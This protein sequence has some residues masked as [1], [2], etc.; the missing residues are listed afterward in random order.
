MNKESSIWIFQSPKYWR[1]EDFS[2]SF[3]DLQNLEAKPFSSLAQTR[4]DKPLTAPLILRGSTLQAKHAKLEAGA[5]ETGIAC[6][7]ALMKVSF[8]QAIAAGCV[9]VTAHSNESLEGT[10]SV[11]SG[12]APLVFTSFRF[13]MWE[14][15]VVF[16]RGVKAARL[17]RI[18][19]KGQIWYIEKYK[20]TSK[21]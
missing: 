19:I 9:G 3:H 18:T 13:E 17:W 21:K 7:V 4:K 2:F 14:A 6:V 10:V 1:Y 16:P 11:R 12:F 8:S 5:C 15:R 20:I